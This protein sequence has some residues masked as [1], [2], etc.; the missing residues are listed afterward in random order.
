MTLCRSAETYNCFRKKP[1]ISIFREE[2]CSA[3]VKTWV[4]GFYEK[5]VLFNQA[6]LHHISNANNLNIQQCKNFKS[7]GTIM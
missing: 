7:Y 6:T 5:L 2:A 4:A 3:T 1:A